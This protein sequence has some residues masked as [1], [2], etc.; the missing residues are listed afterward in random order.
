VQTSC[1]P[2]AYLESLFPCEMIIV[3]VIQVVAKGPICHVIVNEDHLT[4][5]VAESNERDEV[6][7]SK[8][9]KHLDLGPK[10]FGTLSRF[11][12]QALDR[13][14]HVTVVNDTFIYISKTTSANN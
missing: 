1:C 6:D 7:M 2:N 5:I 3:S 11:G 10:L 8:L 4:L 13:H 9:R 12:V 14:S